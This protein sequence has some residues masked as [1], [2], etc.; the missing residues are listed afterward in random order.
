MRIITVRPIL[1][2]QIIATANR[3]TAHGQLTEFGII[4][5]L[6]FGKTAAG[7]VVGR[8]VFENRDQIPNWHRV[9]N[10]GAHPVADAEA[11]A[12]LLAEGFNLKNG[13][14]L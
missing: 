14:I 4:A 5:D 7:C 2:A 8:I 6:V 11:L 10:R 3:L 1:V 9:T 12:R 13:Q